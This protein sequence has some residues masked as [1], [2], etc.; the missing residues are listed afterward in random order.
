MYRV[1]KPG[2][3]AVHQI[4]IDDHLSHY[5][6][7]ASPKQYISY[8]ERV[9]SIAFENEIQYFNRLQMSDWINA[10]R[11]AGFV[12]LHREMETTSIDRLKVSPAFAHYSQEDLACT[13]LT[14]A[15]RRP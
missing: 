4:G 6:R 8:S 1:L 15:F 10:F 13:I 5:D 7:R 3:V 9:W 11:G 2:G 14:V 12:L